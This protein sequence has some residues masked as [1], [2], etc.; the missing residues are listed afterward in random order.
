MGRSATD[1]SAGSKGDEWTDK[2]MH[3]AEEKG[4]KNVPKANLVAWKI[5][6]EQQGDSLLKQPEFDNFSLAWD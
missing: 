3:E 6:A 1:R 4:A 5:R 2:V